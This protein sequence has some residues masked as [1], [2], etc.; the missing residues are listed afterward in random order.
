MKIP[1]SLTVLAASAGLVLLG[2]TTGGTAS[3]GSSALA[4]PSNDSID[5]ATPLGA[6]P[7]LHVEDTS[8]ATHAASDAK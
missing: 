3:A 5:S 8:Q 2:F 7:A 4:A 1:R 6:P